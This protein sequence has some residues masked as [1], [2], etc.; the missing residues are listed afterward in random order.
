MKPHG[1]GSPSA[2]GTSAVSSAS[3]APIGSTGCNGLLTN[4]VKPLAGG[5]ACYAAWLTPQGRMITDVI[6][7]ERESTGSARTETGETWLDVPAPLASAL[8][9]RMDGMIFA[10]DVRVTDASR[11]LTS[12]GIYGPNAGVHVERDNPLPVATTD[13][14]AIVWTQ[15][16]AVGLAGRHAYLSPARAA[17]LEESLSHGGATPLDD[18]TARVL[19]VEAGVPEFLVDMGED[20]IPLEAGLDH[21]LSQTKGCYVGQEII[22]RIR[23]RAHGRVA[24]HL[25]GLLPDN[26]NV[27]PAGQA[28]TSEGRQAGRLTSA[29]M[30]RALGRPIALATLLR[31]FTEP[32]TRV[33]LEDG[34][35]AVVTG[36]PFVPMSD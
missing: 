29:V 27:P 36:L 2:D 3:R 32:G 10:E 25:V 11:E 4:D 16:M 6:V 18:E 34:V 20:T 28:V 14:G 33:T 9:G 35:T 22:V 30:S 24:R 26:Q 13:D 17:G 19:R 8:A 21:T 12:V 5:G 31:E 7:V 23:D 15:A 1:R